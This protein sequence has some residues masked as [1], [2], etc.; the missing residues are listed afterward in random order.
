M[1]WM[2]STFQSSWGMIA[3]DFNA[4]GKYFNEDLSWDEVMGRMPGYA[5]LTGNE[6]DSTVASSSNAY[7][8]IIASESLV[9]DPPA[10]FVIENHVDLS[11]I[12]SQGCSEGYVPSSVCLSSTIDW[13]V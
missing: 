1:C 12:K 4:D 8:R 11:T 9:V 2:K 6:L 13:A 3:G 7:D 5:L 10:V